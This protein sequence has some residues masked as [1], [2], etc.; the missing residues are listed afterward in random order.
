MPTSWMFQA[1]YVVM[2]L[3]EKFILYFL[4]RLKLRFFLSFSLLISLK[5]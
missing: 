3:R 4:V 2:V 1:E 5:A